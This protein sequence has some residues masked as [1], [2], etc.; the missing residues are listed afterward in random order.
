MG[1][2]QKGGM[3]MVNKKRD[4]SGQAFTDRG[5][6]SPYGY[7]KNPSGYNDGTPIG[8]A[9]SGLVCSGRSVTLS[10]TCGTCTPEGVGNG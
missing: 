10:G 4:G 2:A 1:G 9:I 8:R 3:G 5:H 6:I 7:S